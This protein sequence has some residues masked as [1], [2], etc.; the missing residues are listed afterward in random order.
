MCVCEERIHVERIHVA[1][2]LQRESD[3]LCEKKRMLL[4]R[5]YAGSLGDAG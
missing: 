4:Q 2:V 3:I 1:V 5:K